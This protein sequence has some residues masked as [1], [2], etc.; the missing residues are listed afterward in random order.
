VRGHGPVCDSD[1]CAR[2]PSIK[3]ANGRIDFDGMI[4]ENFLQTQWRKMKWVLAQRNYTVR[5][6]EI[7]VGHVCS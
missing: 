3:T 6:G 1:K 5:P 2:I 4:R 7:M